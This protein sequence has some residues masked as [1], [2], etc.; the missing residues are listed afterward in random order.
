MKE[1]GR[2]KRTKAK[3]AFVKV[4][5]KNYPSKIRSLITQLALK[6]VSKFNFLKKHPTLK[7]FFTYQWRWMLLHHVIYGSAKGSAIY[8]QRLS[9]LMH[10]SKKTID[11]TVKECLEA[12]YFIQMKPHKSQICKKIKNIRPSE[13]LMIDYV[14]WQLSRLK[15][16]DHTKRK[17]FKD[18]KI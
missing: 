7:Y 2:M 16:G 13:E 10:I 12:G 6:E 15:K 9:K 14:N 1:I 18:F 17:Y 5:E 8:S 3:F 11:V 4:P